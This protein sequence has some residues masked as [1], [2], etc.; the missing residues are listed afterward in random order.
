MVQR[1]LAGRVRFEGNHQLLNHL[2]PFS[3]KSQTCIYKLIIQFTFFNIYFNLLN[4]KQTNILLDDL[5][6]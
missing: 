2:I 4:L 1:P 5:T 3:T 6:C